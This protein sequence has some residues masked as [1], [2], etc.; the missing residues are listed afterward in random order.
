MPAHMTTLKI[1]LVG[2]VLGWAVISST[3]LALHAAAPIHG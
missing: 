2:A 3:L 1:R